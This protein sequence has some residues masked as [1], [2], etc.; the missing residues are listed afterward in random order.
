MQ[1]NHG[2][3]CASASMHA[4]TNGS[5]PSNNGGTSFCLPSRRSPQRCGDLRQQRTGGI[6]ETIVAQ[7]HR[8]EHERTQ[9]ACAKC[10]GVLHARERVCRTVETMVGPVQL[11]WPY[12]YCRSCRRG[13]S[14][15]SMKR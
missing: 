14:P 4:L 7:G 1:A 9:V 8:G 10:T 15:S 5:I 3:P 6:T 12:C 13:R 11:E 2:T